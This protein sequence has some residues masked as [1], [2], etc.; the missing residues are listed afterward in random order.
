M[1]IESVGKS[2]YLYIYS[3]KDKV[4]ITGFVHIIDINNKVTKERQLLIKNTLFRE[5]TDNNFLGYIYTEEDR[6]VNNLYRTIISN[7]DKE[8]K[9]MNLK[10]NI[11]EDLCQIIEFINSRYCGI[12]NVLENK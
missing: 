2:K 3:V 11:I 1:L 4:P 12:Q 8:I 5:L 6:L 9:D 7:T 10:K